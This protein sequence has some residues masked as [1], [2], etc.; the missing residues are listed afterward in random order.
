MLLMGKNDVFSHAPASKKRPKSTKKKV[1]Q[2]RL[3]VQ[4]LVY[5][6]YTRQQSYNLAIFGA[7]TVR[8]Y[9]LRIE[10]TMYGDIVY[11]ELEYI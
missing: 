4:L 1:G 3:H 5:T 8:Q 7:G 10:C 2:N 11:L 9:R 6:V